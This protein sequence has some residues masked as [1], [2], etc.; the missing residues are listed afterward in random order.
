M[1][2][3]SGFVLCF[4]GPVFVVCLVVLDTVCSSPW[5]VV[6]R[7][8]HGVMYFLLFFLHD[9]DDLIFDFWFER[10]YSGIQ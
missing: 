1:L 3:C 8:F 9:I 10:P 6:L 2:S 4:S 7:S 5:F